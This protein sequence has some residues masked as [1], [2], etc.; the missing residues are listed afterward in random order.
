MSNRGQANRRYPDPAW[1]AY[2]RVGDVLRFRGSLR[3]VRAVHRD[4]DGCL[5]AVYFAPRSRN[6]GFRRPYTLYFATELRTPFSRTEYIGAR[7][8]L[9][10][11]LDQQLADCLSDDTNGWPHGL[12]SCDT[13]GLP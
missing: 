8:K 7:L 1:F 9:D 10:G 3:V 12:T 4:T 2:L 6:T 11:P 5:R 13:V